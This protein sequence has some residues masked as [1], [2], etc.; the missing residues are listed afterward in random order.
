MW[1]PPGGGPHITAAQYGPSPGL[2]SEQHLLPETALGARVG[3]LGADTVQH[4]VNRCDP[5]VGHLLGP[6]HGP[7]AVRRRRGLSRRTGQ[8]FCF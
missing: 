3:V 8:L 1:G 2:R 7:D 4:L 5:F 6:A